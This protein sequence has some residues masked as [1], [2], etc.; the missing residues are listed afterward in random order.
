MLPTLASRLAAYAYVMSHAGMD[1]SQQL[2]TQEQSHQHPSPASVPL[3]APAYSSSLCC[4]IPTQN[5]HPER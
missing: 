3:A 4:S 5:T 1:H 2:H